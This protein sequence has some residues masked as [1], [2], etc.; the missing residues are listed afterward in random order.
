MYV[1][2]KENESSEEEEEE[3]EDVSENYCDV[4]GVHGDLICCDSC[5]KVYHKQ[6]HDPPMRNIPRLEKML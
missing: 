1:F 4:C 3:E 2:L 5:P 6:C